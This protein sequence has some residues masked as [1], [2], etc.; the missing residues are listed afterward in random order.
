M[1]V[2][3]ARGAL[4]KVRLTS[5]GYILAAKCTVINFVGYLN[6][7]AAIYERLRPIQ[8]MHV[9]VHLG[10]ID[11]DRPYFY[12]SIAEIIYIIFLSFRGKLIS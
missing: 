12:N 7:E 10:N 4:F 3:G 2:Y 5:H 11:L 6:Q 1:G 9:P 8:G